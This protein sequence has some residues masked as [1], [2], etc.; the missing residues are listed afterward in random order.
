MREDVFSLQEG[1]LV[2]QWPDE[3]SAD[4]LQEVFEYL[5]IWKRIRLRDSPAGLAEFNA[6][7]VEHDPAPKNPSPVGLVEQLCGPICSA[8]GIPVANCDCA[9]ECVPASDLGLGNRGVL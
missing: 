1:Q 8:S 3:L 9:E 7:P 6:S 2:I 5:E 4:S